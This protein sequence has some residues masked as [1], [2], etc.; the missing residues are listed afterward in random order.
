MILF[1]AE[2]LTDLVDQLV[3]L[4]RVLDGLLPLQVELMAFLMKP[5]EF[6]GSFVKFNLGGLGLRHFLLKLLAL[7]A[8]F[9]RELLNLE[10]EFLDLGLVSAAVLLKGEVVLLLLTGGE[11]PL[12]ELL[13]VPVHFQ[14]ELVHA[15]ISLEDHVLDVVEAVLLV[16]DALLKLLYFVL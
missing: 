3:T 4:A 14:F 15:L 5:F 10:S 13:L 11:G 16:S 6:F 12:L 9:N 8:H 2:V 7:V 1:L